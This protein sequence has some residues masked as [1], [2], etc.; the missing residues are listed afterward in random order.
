M[1]ADY[2]PGKALTVSKDISIKRKDG[3]VAWKSMQKVYHS[4]TCHPLSDWHTPLNSA[5]QS[6]KKIEK[7]KKHTTAGTRLRSPTKLLIR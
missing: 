1:L 2:A 3:I 6:H 5:K 4:E 7:L